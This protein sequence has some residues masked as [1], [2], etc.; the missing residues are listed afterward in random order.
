MK[1]SIF[2]GYGPDDALGAEIHRELL[3]FLG[4]RGWEADDMDLTRMKIAPCIGCFTCWL[5]T[6]GICCQKDEGRETAKSRASADA[7][8]V[9]SRVTFGGYSS[10]VK[11]AMDRNVPN[12]LPF[13]IKHQGEMHH[14][15]RY[16][17]QG[18][19]SLG[20]QDRYEEESAGIFTRLAERNARNMQATAQGSVV[21]HGG[22]SAE[23]RR[24][25]VETLL[26]DLEARP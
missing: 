6:P 26:K 15:Q 21:V 5:K 25:A 7:L 1:L 2:R 17:R 4:K 16:E 18:F 22:Q 24:E 20:W 10:R 9:L 8:I 12:V 19:L 23:E 11:A 13:F 3:D 14:P